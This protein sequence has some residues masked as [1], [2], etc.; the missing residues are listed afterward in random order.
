MRGDVQTRE[1][2]QNTTGGRD[3]ER[4]SG[5]P[6]GPQQNPTEQQ[7]ARE[8]KPATPDTTVVVPEVHPEPRQ[9]QSDEQQAA[10]SEAINELH[11]SIDSHTDKSPEPPKDRRGGKKQ[12]SRAPANQA[13]SKWSYTETT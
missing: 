1:V 12:S 5:N 4:L 2:A 7:T 3:V 11:R 9:P 10:S 8:R 13:G 6:D